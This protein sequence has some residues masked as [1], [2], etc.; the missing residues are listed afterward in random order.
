MVGRGLVPTTTLGVRTLSMMGVDGYRPVVVPR[1]WPKGSRGAPATGSRAERA[2]PGDEGVIGGG[3][4]AV[5]HA[6]RATPQ[7]R[8][9]ATVPALSERCGK[10]WVGMPATP[11]DN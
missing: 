11:F 9:V 3:E 2:H 5:A 10:D 6:A 8:H 1:A 7:P 4:G